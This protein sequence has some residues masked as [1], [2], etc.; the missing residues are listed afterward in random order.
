MSKKEKTAKYA[1]SYNPSNN[2]VTKTELATGNTWD[3]LSRPKHGKPDHTPSN[4]VTV[5]ALQKAG[6]NVRVKHLRWAVYWGHEA[7]L[8]NNK[9]AVS[10]MMVVPS[11]FR[12]DPNYMFLPKGGYTHVVIKKKDGEYVCVS[13][14]CS[15][16][17]PFCYGAGVARAL[18]RLT[19][20]VIS[21]LLSADEL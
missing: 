16:E 21:E 12:K 14:E 20:K 11:T 18:E 1:Y 4:G 6:H 9:G 17:D 5:N 13:S 19:R 15:V 8:K 7:M 2:L 3:Y 10:R